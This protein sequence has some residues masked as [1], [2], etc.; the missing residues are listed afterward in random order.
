MFTNAPPGDTP[1]GNWY[2]FFLIIILGLYQLI[3]LRGLTKMR[4][5]VSRTLYGKKTGYGI[6]VL[7]ELYLV[8]AISLMLFAA[9]NFFGGVTPFTRN[10]LAGSSEGLTIMIISGTIMIVLRAWYKKHI[11]DPFFKETVA[12]SLIKDLILVVGMT[13]YFYGYINVMVDDF[14]R[15]FNLGPNSYL[16]LIG[17]GLYIWGIILLIPLRAWARQHQRFGIMEQMMHVVVPSL[18]SDSRKSLVKKI[19]TAISEMPEKAMLKMVKFHMM[20]LQK[21]PDEQRQSLIKT[22]LIVLSELPSENRARMMKA[23]DSVT[24]QMQ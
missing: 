22:Q 12:Q 23:M 1:H 7:K 19:V 24:M 18:D 3:P 2:A 10:V 16:T 14:P 4:T 8:V 13:F 21:M 5:M 20:N 9:H 11:G 17:L 15:S 6:T